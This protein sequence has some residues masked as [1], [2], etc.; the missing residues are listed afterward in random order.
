M[1]KK[2]E[3]AEEFL[4]RNRNARPDAGF[5]FRVGFYVTW[6]PSNDVGDVA[7]QMISEASARHEYPFTTTA[8][9]LVCMKY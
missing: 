8:K 7:D 9:W 1:G 5:L 2:L 3:E 6:Q 4:E